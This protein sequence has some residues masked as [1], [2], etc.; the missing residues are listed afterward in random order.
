MLVPEEEIRDRNKAVLL[1]GQV[2]MVMI[3]TKRQTN[4]SQVFDMDCQLIEGAMV[5]VW[6]FS[7]TRG[8][9]TKLEK[10]LT[11]LR[12]KLHISL[13]PLSVPRAWMPRADIPI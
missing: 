4:C 11:S 9:H 12:R 6:Y 8:I 2:V 1:E 10:C 13:L 3:A 7:P 5:E